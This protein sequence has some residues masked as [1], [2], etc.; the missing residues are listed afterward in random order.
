MSGRFVSD[1]EWR[2]ATTPALFVTDR[3][4]ATGVE[5]R[6]ASAINGS[7]HAMRGAR[8]Q[9]ERFGS[10]NVLRG[11]LV[12][13]LAEL[14]A[15]LKV[16]ASKL[17]TLQKWLTSLSWPA[18]AAAREACDLLTEQLGAD[19]QVRD[20]GRGAGQSLL[21]LVDIAAEL[22]ALEA[23]HATPKRLRRVAA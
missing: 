13:L 16:D 4:V 22:E 5:P 8:A 3:A 10:Q 11:E 23:E 18:L 2:R 15:V 6:I 21:P 1:E 9:L 20:D 7:A 17:P 14:F 19:A 12:E